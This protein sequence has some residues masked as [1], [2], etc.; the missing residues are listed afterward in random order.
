MTVEVNCHHQP[1]DQCQ[2][3]GA[4]AGNQTTNW[5]PQ[6]LVLVSNRIYFDQRKRPDRVYM[7]EGPRIEKYP[8][9]TNSYQLIF[10]REYVSH[11]N[12]ENNPTIPNPTAKIIVCSVMTSIQPAILYS[13][14]TRFSPE[15]ADYPS[16]ADRP[17]LFHERWLDGTNRVRE[18]LP[19]NLLTS[20]GQP[21]SPRN[22]SG[23][24]NQ[25]FSPRNMSELTGN[26]YL[27]R[28]G[29]VLNQALDGIVETTRPELENNFASKLETIVSGTFLAVFSNL[30]P[31]DSQ[32][33]RNLHKTLPQSMMPESP[34]YYPPEPRVITMTPSN[35][36]YGFR[37]SSRT[38]I[39]G[40][41]I[42]I[43]HAVIVVLGSLWQLLWQRS[44]ITAWETIPD[45]LALG[46]GSVIPPEDVLNNTC[47]G[48][49]ATK[50]LQKI[51]RVGETTHQ[52]LEIAVEEPGPWSIMK[53]V[54][55][56]HEVKY[57]AVGGGG[58]EKLE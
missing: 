45:Y 39:L 56:K 26:P 49:A 28:F 52:H 47:A 25:P 19:E 50:S 46:L 36:G 2:I 41:T 22:V 48:I 55:G 12:G 9:F 42:L 1:K 32:Y 30:Q 35:R 3:T 16:P 54:L 21:Y 38:G 4:S 20:G 24:I 13:L 8:E 40:I 37:L 6:G 23:P 34:V 14:A 15:Y 5:C 29:D 33:P 18:K 27:N 11:E 51:V 53:S 10:D 58:K 17:I 43:T 7:T 57:G 31:S 44:V